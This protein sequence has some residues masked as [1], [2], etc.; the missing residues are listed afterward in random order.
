MKK[1]KH[2]IALLI[3]LM[4]LLSTSC[5][6]AEELSI[7]EP[8]EGHLKSICRLSVLEGYYHNVV[9]YNNPNPKKGFLAPKNTHFWVEY[10]GVARYG[11]DV[12]KVKM[13]IQGK[14]IT[15]QLPK[16][17]ILYCKVDSTSLN[18]DSYIIAKDSAKVTSED[19]KNA[20]SQA[21]HEL[22]ENAENDENL[23]LSAQNRA[24]ELIEAYIKNLVSVSGN[25]ENE[26]KI[27]WVYL[28]EE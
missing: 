11:L 8:D 16:A 24:Q 10:T 18:S 14:E 17:K 21:Q 20:L 22:R 19:S 15:I 6:K 12:S 25:D 5:K 9:K 2:I 28:D 7:I 4:L 26:Y 3:V 13:D 27:N 23:L 1:E